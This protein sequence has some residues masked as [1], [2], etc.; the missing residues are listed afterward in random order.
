MEDFDYIRL[1]QVQYDKKYAAAPP[2]KA[3]HWHLVF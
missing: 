2:V 1:H 3:K